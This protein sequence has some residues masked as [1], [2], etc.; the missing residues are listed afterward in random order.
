MLEKFA[1]ITR[2]EVL[3]KLVASKVKIEGIKDDDEFKALL[4]GSLI[5]YPGR[6]EKVI[7]RFN[8]YRSYK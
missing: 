1:P 5:R 3:E 2:L 8:A 6:V 7:K 4:F